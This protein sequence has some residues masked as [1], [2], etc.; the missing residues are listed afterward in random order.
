MWPNIIE[1]PDLGMFELIF[2]IGAETIQY[3]CT[4]PEISL[5]L[6]ALGQLLVETSEFGGSTN[7]AFR[8][9]RKQK[10]FSP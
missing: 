2:I 9:L 3:F 1:M 4:F 7:F 6:G 10:R 5:C 8:S